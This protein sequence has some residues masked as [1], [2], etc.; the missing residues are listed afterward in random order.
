MY[1]VSIDNDRSYDMVSSDLWYALDG[2]ELVGGER[3]E[4]LYA[5]TMARIAKLKTR[6]THVDVI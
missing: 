6:F 4:E 1:E 3:A 5:R 2:T